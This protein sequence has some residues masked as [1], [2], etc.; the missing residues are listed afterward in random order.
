MDTQQSFLPWIFIRLAGLTLT[1]LS[2]SAETYCQSTIESIPNQKLVNN[3]Y[4]SNPD[5]VLDQSTI[6]QI[7]SILTDLEKTTT[8]QTAVVVVNSIGSE[9]IFD[10]AQKL[11]VKW[12]IGSNGKDNGLLILLVMDQRTVRFHTGYGLEGVLPDVTCKRI[13]GEF[14]VP[15]FK[16][17]NYN[18]GMLAGIEQ[19]RN[20]L[21]NPENA[22]ELQSTTTVSEWSSLLII[23]LVFVFPIILIA[24]IVKNVRGHFANSKRPKKTL[25]GEMRLKRWQWLLEFAIIPGIIVLLFHIGSQNLGLC[26][27]SL[28]LYYMFTLFH[29]LARIKNVIDRLQKKEKYYEVVEFIRKGQVYWFFMALLFPIPFFFY[30]FYHLARK[31]LYRNHSRTCEKCQGSMDKLSEETEDQFLSTSQQMEETLKSVDYDVWKC[32]SCQNTQSWIYPNRHSKYQACPKCKTLA[33]Y[34]SGS[35]TIT[36]ASYSS[37]GEGEQTHT[38][39]YCGNVVVATYSIAQLV[40]SSSS[41]SSS[42]SSSSSSSDSGSWGGGSSGGGGASSSW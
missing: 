22:E 2:F 10:F 12:G 38:C 40:E 34:P 17:N 8:T 16:K 35:R 14:M 31:K 4:V 3:S 42:S 11:F 29:R 18:A 15:E 9:D 30:F 21:T 28:Y 32:N 33:Y 26:F 20:M 24:F 7:D 6:S 23:L 19:V 39:K 1:L 36:S 27:F 5:G 41:D 13:Q 25:Y 37:S